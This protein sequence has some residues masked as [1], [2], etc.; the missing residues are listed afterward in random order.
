MVLYKATAGAAGCRVE[1][2]FEGLRAVRMWGMGGCTVDD[3]NPALPRIRN[4]P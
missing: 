4:I 2:G 1:Q 3:V